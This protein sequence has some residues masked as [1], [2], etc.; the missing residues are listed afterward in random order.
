MLEDKVTEFYDFIDDEDLQSDEGYHRMI[1]VCPDC[2]ALFMMKACGNRS[3]F[4]WFGYHPTDGNCKVLTEEVIEKIRDATNKCECSSN[5][6]R[7]TTKKFLDEC[8]SKI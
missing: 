2:G 6:V 5:L 3:I 7:I 8:V 4:S 1:L